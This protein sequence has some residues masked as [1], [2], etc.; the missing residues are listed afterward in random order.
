M[1][2]LKSLK[3]ALFLIV[4]FLNIGLFAQIHDDSYSISAGV[5]THYGA[6]M[7]GGTSAGVSVTLFKYVFVSLGKISEHNESFSLGGFALGFQIPFSYTPHGNA[8]I[9]ASFGAVGTFNF[10]GATANISTISSNPMGGMGDFGTIMGYDLQVGYQYFV[11]NK[12]FILGSIGYAAGKDSGAQSDLDRYNRLAGTTIGP[13][14]AYNSPN[15]TRAP[16]YKGVSYSAG[17]G[18]AF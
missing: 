16:E 13:G 11:S 9:S 6:P 8:F 4:W 12:I 3:H 17:L 14:V 7:F 18:F 1:V 5:G 2:K 15:V 10:S